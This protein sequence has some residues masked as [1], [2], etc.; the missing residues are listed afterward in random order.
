V[1]GRSVSLLGDG[2][3]L[4][5]HLDEELEV[6]DD[7][8]LRDDAADLFDIDLGDGTQPIELDG[9]DGDGG[10]AASTDSDTHGTS[11]M[12]GKRVSAVW[13]Y[14]TEIKENGIRIVAICKHCGN[15]YTARSAV[16]TGHLKMPH[17]I[18]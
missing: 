2:E 15:K 13:S 10:V 1:G 18:L 8:D 16:G 3:D 4:A 5:P 9:D 14:F 17:E 7:D 11:T 12:S 6:K